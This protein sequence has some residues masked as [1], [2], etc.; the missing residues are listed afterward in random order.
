MET[1]ISNPGDNVN[2]SNSIANSNSLRPIIRFGTMRVDRPSST[3]LFALVAENAALRLVPLLPRGF[4]LLAFPYA[5]FSRNITVRELWA[6][7]GE[8]DDDGK[9]PESTG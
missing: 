2:E 6:E 3:E 8:F 5:I 7:Q 1:N 9:C 4:L